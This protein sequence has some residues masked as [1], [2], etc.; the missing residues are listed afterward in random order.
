MAYKDQIKELA[1]TVNGGLTVYI[2][3]HNKIFEE[4][5]TLKSVFKNIFGLGTPM[6]KL[7]EDAETLA[8]LW[9][10]INQKVESFRLSHYS[11]LSKEEQHFLDILS[12]YVAAI[13]KTITMLI[14]R[15]RLL[16]EKSKGGSNNPTTLGKYKQI[17]ATYKTAIQE[18]MAIGQEL[19]SAMST[20]YK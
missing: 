14:E 20:I 2:A 13:Q 9:K 18:Y 5:A 10:A 16:N 6:S 12:R 4:A 8:P 7:L 1:M 19:N 15:Q 11:S 17:E 3:I